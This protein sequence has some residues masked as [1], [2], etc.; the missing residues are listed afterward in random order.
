MLRP[1]ELKTKEIILKPKSKIFQNKDKKIFQEIK[2]NNKE[3]LSSNCSTN[4]SL[5]N[6]EEKRPKEINNR[7][8]R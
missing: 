1:I 4:S 2:L 3:I 6:N 8:T 5:N 7:K